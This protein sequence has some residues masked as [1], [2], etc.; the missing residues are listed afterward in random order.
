MDVTLN[1]GLERPDGGR[2]YWPHVDAVLREGG[3]TVVDGWL[4]DAAPGREETYVV[5]VYAPM[6]RGPF[7]DRIMDAAVKLGQDC[8]AVEYEVGDG[9]LI[10]PHADAWGEFD[11]ELFLE[12]RG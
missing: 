12:C 9:K 11:P 2:V 10:G 8:I 7:E 3:L 1:V 4:A 5:R 6:T